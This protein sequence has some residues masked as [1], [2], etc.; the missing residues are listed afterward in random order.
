[1]VHIPL[2]LY[3]YFLQSV[4]RLVFDE[5][6]P[7]EDGN[8]KEEFLQGDDDDADDNDNNDDH[9]ESGYTPSAF[10][11]ISITPVEVSVICPRRLV[12]KYFAPLRQQLN[13]LD[14]SLDS[15]LDFSDNDYIAMQVI[16]QGLEAG[17][18]VLE[19]TS[20]LAMAGMYV[21]QTTNDPPH[22]MISTFDLSDL[23]IKFCANSPPALS[24]SFRLTSPTTSFSL[25]I[26]KAVWFRH[27]RAE[28][29]S[30]KNQR[31]LL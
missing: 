4:L 19:L 5:L 9:S 3:P 15:Q 16:G 30:S 7:L 10:L 21:Q 29:F 13:E 11:N 18:R 25:S 31:P 26:V 17:K 23:Y 2:D 6:S 27:W 12:D 14:E 20:P 24:F 8:E 28:A 1:L 22:G